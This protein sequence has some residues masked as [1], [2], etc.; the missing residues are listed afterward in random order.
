[1]LMV[2]YESIG[3][4]FWPVIFISLALLMIIYF[5]QEAPWFL[6]IALVPV[7]I[8][9][10]TNS[11]RRKQGKRVIYAVE[12]IRQYAVINGAFLLITIMLLFMIE[13]HIVIEIGVLTILLLVALYSTITFLSYYLQKKSL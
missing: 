6:P 4:I 8:Y 11:V 3:K 5:L 2:S 13:G 1:M 10:T 12:N 9:P 7:V